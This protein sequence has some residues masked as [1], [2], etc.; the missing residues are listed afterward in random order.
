MPDHRCL[1]DRRTLFASAAALAVASRRSSLAR[2][3]NLPD[4]GAANPPVANAPEP[5]RDPASYA[6]YV[7]TASKVGQFF[8]FTCEF[9]AAWAVLASFGIDAP[10]ADQLAFCGQDVDPEPSYQETDA[11]VLILGGNVAAAYCGD[12]TSNFLA[13]MRG[14]AMSK[15]FIGYG[16][17]AEHARTR[18]QIE[19][20]LGRGDLVWL[21]TTVDFKDWVPA[22]WITPAGTRFPAVLGNDHAVVAIGYDADVV[23]IRDVLGP[24]STNWERPYEIEVPWDRFLTCFAAQGNDGLAVGSGN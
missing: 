3:A 23:V 13:R 15:V 14:S 5:L 22:T 9:D 7:P 17:R 18:K 16:L 8:H 6:A 21:K 1:L 10:F 4:P 19:A 2:A 12:Y 24:T 20:A 11:G